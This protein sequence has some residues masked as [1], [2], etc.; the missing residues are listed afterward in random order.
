MKSAIGTAYDQVR[1]ALTGLHE[2]LPTRDDFAAKL[3]AC[4]AEFGDTT[5]LRA[6]L[7]VADA[8][9]LMMPPVVQTQA[10][11]IVRESLVNIRRHA[12]AQQVQ[13]QIGRVN[14]SARFVI[15]D[16]GRG[17]DLNNVDGG[18]HLGLGI[19]RTRAERCGGSLDVVSTPGRG[20]TISATL[21]LVEEQKEQLCLAPAL[22]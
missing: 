17:F 8:T 9:A 11:H 18:Q 5:G 22:C 14:G 2:P 13:V 20:T 15:A 7:I 10:L 21:P 1:A 12:Q 19:M 16:D 3:S 6:E 4:V